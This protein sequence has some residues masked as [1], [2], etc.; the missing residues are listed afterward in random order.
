M[1]QVV[2]IKD[3]NQAKEW[4]FIGI[5]RAVLTKHAKPLLR[6]DGSEAWGDFKPADLLHVLDAGEIRDTAA[7]SIVALWAGQRGRT[8]A[9]LAAARAF[10]TQWPEGPQ[11]QTVKLLGAEVSEQ[12]LLKR[13]NRV[14]AK[15]GQ[16]VR[17]P[18]NQRARVDLGPY[19]V[20]DFKRNW[21]VA[22][23]IDLEGW[24]RDLDCL[25]SGETVV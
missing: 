14:L 13:I 15:R 17:R 22:T 2:V 11:I 6:V 5:R 21:I 10:L 16:R 9:E 19:Y 3:E 12:A 18:R 23:D 8:A 25:S 20:Q 24:G 4:G 1:K 7:A